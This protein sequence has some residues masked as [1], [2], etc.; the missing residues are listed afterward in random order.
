MKNVIEIL[1][2]KKKECEDILMFL[3]GNDKECATLIPEIDQALQL[4]QPAVVGRSEQC[5]K[6]TESTGETKL[7]CCN[8]CGRRTESF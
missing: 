6:C 5:G 2:D 8:H 4:L 1:L 7:W 3:N